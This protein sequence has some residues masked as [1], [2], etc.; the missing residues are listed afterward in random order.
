MV[1]RIP[2][3]RDGARALRSLYDWM[4]TLVG[5][6]LGLCMLALF[7]FIEAIFIF[8]AGPLLILFCSEQPKR[9]YFYA[10]VAT[11]FSVLGGIVAYYIGSYV[12]ELVGQKLVALV[13]TQEKFSYLCEQY[14]QHEA[15]AILVAGATPLPFKV[16]TLSA[17]FCR[18]AF[19][20]FVTCCL[21]I[22]SARMLLIATIMFW[23][24]AS[25]KEHINRY[26][27]SLV[28]LFIFLIICTLFVIT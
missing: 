28:A 3:V 5:K 15:F 16:I 14:Q 27:N 20:P 1:Q 4:G 22:R 19:I 12:W 9:S 11:L 23:W 24:G 21:I 7:F 18:V 10:L 8:P 6:P 25:I 2:I 17:G 26:F 13:T